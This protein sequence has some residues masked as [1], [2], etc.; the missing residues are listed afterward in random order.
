MYAQRETLTKREQ[1]LNRIYARYEADKNPK[2]P[3]ICPVKRTGGT[4]KCVRCGAMKKTDKGTLCKAC[5]THINRFNMA[6]G[7]K[8]CK[9][10]G[11]VKRTSFG[12]LCRECAN[13]GNGEKGMEARGCK[14]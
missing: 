13:K 7:R 12:E 14:I 5:Q 8:Y 3:I 1:R 9:T 10:C 6:E 11:K 4:I 2:K